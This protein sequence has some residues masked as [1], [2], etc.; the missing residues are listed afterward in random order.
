M[1]NKWH[2]LYK[3]LIFR[4]LEIKRTDVMI[5]NLEKFVKSVIGKK[6]SVSIKKLFKKKSDPTENE[7]ENYEKRTFFCS[8]L[9]ATAYKYLGLLPKEISATQYFPGLI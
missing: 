1:K 6:F 7:T 4:K 2:K 9:V 8:E 5:E 3:K